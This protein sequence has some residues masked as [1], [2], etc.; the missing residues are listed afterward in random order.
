M[1]QSLSNNGADSRIVKLSGAGRLED[2]RD[3]VV[4]PTAVDARAVPPTAHLSG[5]IL[6]PPSLQKRND[7]IRLRK[8]FLN[9]EPIQ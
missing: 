4:L 9:Q 6:S 8:A 2:F 7:L 3:Q 5:V 1:K